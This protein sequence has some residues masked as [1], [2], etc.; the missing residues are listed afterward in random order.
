MPAT[1]DVGIATRLGRASIHDPRTRV[2]TPRPRVATIWDES[3]RNMTV[4]AIDITATA[5]HSAPA[6]RNL[7]ILPP[8]QP[9]STAYTLSTAYTSSMPRDVKTHR[10]L[11]TESVVDAALRL[12]DEGGIDA[13]SIRRLASALEVTPMAIYRHVR[14]KGHL[15][16]LMA[17]RLIGQLALAPPDASTWQ[18]ALRGVAESLLAVVQAHPAAPFLLARPFESAAALRISE[19]MLAILGR[20]GFGPV[21]SLRLM[22]VLTGMILGPAIHR[23]T[24]AHAWRELPTVPVDGPAAST[25]LPAAEFPY[26]SKVADQLMD[27]S[28]GPAI[29][30]LTIELW[31]ASV[32]ELADR[33]KRGIRFGNGRRRGSVHTGGMPRHPRSKAKG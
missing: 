27:W 25:A 3:T 28:Q 18:D 5:I 32:E 19:T 30:Q 21:E 8:I 7:C 12:A 24:Y 1:I 17:D 2:A 10:G 15:L 22:Q 9:M 29:D 20:A 33:E 4:A 6:I 11:T 13:V 31:V 26:L 14:D 16:D 23:A